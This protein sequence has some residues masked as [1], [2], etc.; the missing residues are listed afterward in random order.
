MRAIILAAGRGERMGALTA[1][2]PKPL[3]R[4]AG[5]YLIEYA[6]LSL[7]RARITEIVINVCYHRE[8]I[9]AALGDGKRYGAT[10]FYSE[11]QE[12]LETGG[13]ILHALP[14][15]GDKPFVVLSGDVITDYSLNQLPRE[16][17][18][19]AH[20][21]MVTNPAY[22]SLGDFGLRAGRLDMQAKPTLTFGNISVLRPELF[23]GDEPGHFRLAT[24]FIPAILRGELTGEH[25]QGTWY[26]IG[27]AADLEY[28][29]QR[30]RED[31]NLWPLA[32][33]TN[34]LSN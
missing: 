12:R 15:L 13:G 34:T 19:L 11:E 29:N 5:Y 1:H 7:V 17:D 6:I 22:N 8:Q 14:L 4:V 24:K 3:L 21:I 20:L 30:A 9:K 31:S 28:V 32:S 16:P 10:L 33:E 18:G 26:N 2:V 25:Y 27:T 23:A